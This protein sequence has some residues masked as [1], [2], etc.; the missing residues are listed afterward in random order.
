MSTMIL[1][2]LRWGDGWVTVRDDGCGRIDDFNIATTYPDVESAKAAAESTGYTDA[3]VV[4]VEVAEPERPTAGTL[5]A[6]AH[7]AGGHGIAV[8]AGPVFG[9]PNGNPTSACMALDGIGGISLDSGKPLRIITPTL[10]R[11]RWYLEQS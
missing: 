10:L 6:L 1:Y 11:E 4:P 9:G 7:V 3:F 5:D 2:A 8:A